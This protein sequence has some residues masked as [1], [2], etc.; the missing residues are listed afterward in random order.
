MRKT[1]LLTLIL[2]GLLFSCQ[3][4]KKEFKETKIVK[5][6]KID[7]TEKIERIFVLTTQTAHWFQ[8][9]NFTL[10]STTDLPN[11]KQTLYNYQ[12]NSKVFIK[13]LSQ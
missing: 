9:R 11:T 10:S 5:V 1:L 6:E 8:E 3:D 12:R 4:N 2:S 7:N 13:R